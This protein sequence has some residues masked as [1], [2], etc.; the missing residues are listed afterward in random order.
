MK[1]I[2]IILV[3]LLGVTPAY[4]DDPC[5][6]GMCSISM[7]VTTGKTTITRLSDAE[8][9]I[10]LAVIAEQNRLAE[11]AKAEADRLAAI[12]EAN[13][14]K[15][16]VVDTPTATIPTPVQETI[17]ATSVAVMETKTA[18]I[19]TP[20]A[21]SQPTLVTPTPTQPTASIATISVVDTAV[22]VNQS[23]NVATSQTAVTA[24]SNVI[25]AMKNQILLIQKLYAKI[26]TR[27][28]GIK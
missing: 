7:N 24:L 1:K 6:D 21:T 9:A 18:Q 23:T 2:I 11:I 15:P 16:V 8:I 4:A 19:V 20:V 22:V 13:K 10:R 27:T 25:W 17:T 3:M 5:F 14:P 12:A 26:L 28:K